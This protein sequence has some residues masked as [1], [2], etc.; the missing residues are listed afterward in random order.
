MKIYRKGTGEKYTP[1]GHFDMTTQVIFNPDTGSKNA[2]VTLSTLVKGAGSEDEIH[3]K[4]DQIFCVVQGEL[5]I[6][7]NGRLL[8]VLHAGD[9][10]LIEAGDI[11]AVG[12][13]GEDDCVFYA[14][15]VPPLDKT[16]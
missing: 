12:N 14:I 13:D 10:V 7:A 4:S 11:H 16:H 9:A 1:F 8:Q 3:E 2:N 6:S 5:K 15:T